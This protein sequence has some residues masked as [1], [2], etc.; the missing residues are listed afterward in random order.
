MSYGVSLLHDKT[1]GSSLTWTLPVSTTAQDPSDD[2]S[3]YIGIMKC[4]YIT[5][6]MWTVAVSSTKFSILLLYMRLFTQLRKSRW[7]IRILFGIVICWTVITVGE[8]SRKPLHSPTDGRN[9]RWSDIHSRAN[10]FPPIGM[11]F[12]LK[13]PAHCLGIPIGSMLLHILSLIY[14]Y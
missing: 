11:N 7:I 6:I 12:S 5:Y 14:L 1:Y 13:K 2:I 9:I 8:H 4:E 3:G 10:L